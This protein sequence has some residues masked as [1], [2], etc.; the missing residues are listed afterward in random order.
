MSNIWY[1]LGIPFALL[2]SPLLYYSLFKVH[3]VKERYAMREYRL[4]SVRLHRDFYIFL[5]IVA[6]FIFWIIL[7]KYIENKVGNQA[8]SEVFKKI[9]E[10]AIDKVEEKV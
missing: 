2:I 4:C 7:K 9:E 3:L 8:T 10:K 6:L 1:L 5:L